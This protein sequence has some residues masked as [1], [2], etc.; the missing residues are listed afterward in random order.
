ME[1]KTQNK[2]YLGHLFGHYGVPMRSSSHSRSFSPQLPPA[3]LGQQQTGT[4]LVNQAGKV[5]TFS[6]T[7]TSVLLKVKGM[8]QPGAGLHTPSFPATD[9]LSVHLRGGVAS[10]E[11]QG[12]VGKSP[13]LAWDWV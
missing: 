8:A 11:H 5:V 13:F 4:G 12:E 10:A 3:A 7:E 9:P 2:R 1:N 6:G